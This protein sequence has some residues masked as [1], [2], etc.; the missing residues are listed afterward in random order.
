MVQGLHV[1]ARFTY[2]VN[3]R[4]R[5]PKT[6]LILPFTNPSSGLEFF[7]PN[8]S[9]CISALLLHTQGTN[10]MFVAFGADKEHTVLD[11]LIPAQF[12]KRNMFQTLEK[13]VV[14]GNPEVF[15]LN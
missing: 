12:F 14:E 8:I 1:L 13:A 11:I 6:Q 5:D 3:L 15:S 4:V 9:Q 10:C 7:L 2:S